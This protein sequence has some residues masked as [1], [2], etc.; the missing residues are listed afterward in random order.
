MDSERIDRWCERGIFG[1]VLLIL[2]FGP[3]AI[4]AVRWFEFIYIEAAT[5]VI[6]ILWLIRS[7]VKPTFELFWPPI[8]W[9]VLAFLLYALGRY[10]TADIEYVARLEFLRICVYAVLFLAVLNNVQRQESIQIII[11]ALV[12]LATCLSLYALVQFATKSAYVWHFQKPANYTYRG[13]G[14]FI[15]PN[16]LAGFLEIAL[17]VALAMVVLGRIG[18]VAKILLGY[19]CAVMLVG[20]GV[21]LSR[22]GWIAT[23]L[24]L[25]CFFI[26]L[27]VH[28]RSRWIIIL[29]MLLV[30]GASAAYIGGS[31]EFQNRFKKTFITGKVGDAR[32]DYWKPAVQ[33][34]KEHPWIGIG[35][36]HYEIRFPQFRPREVQMHPQYAHNDYLNTLADWGIIGAVIVLSFILLLYLG[37]LKAAKFVRRKTNLGDGKSDRLALIFGCSFGVLGL[38]FHSVTDFNMQIP[39][40]AI[41]LLIVVALAMTHLRHSDSFW[42]QNRIAAKSLATIFLL[43]VVSVMSFYGVRKAQENLWLQRA[44]ATPLLDEKLAALRRAATIEKNN[45]KTLNTLG[46]LLRQAS[47]RADDGDPR[48]AEEALTWFQKG[49]KTDPFSP[50]NYLGCGMSLDWLGRTKESGPY[51]EKALAIDPNSYYVVA[52]Q[53]WHAVQLGDYPAAEKWFEKSLGL[54]WTDFAV[55]YINIVRTKLAEAKAGR[56]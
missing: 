49:I 28:S 25:L 44:Q 1:L 51:F 54:S 14:T 22:G 7:W 23:T 8:C 9:P 11:W 26:A 13:S 12:I 40:N 43:A 32:F 34:W 30:F 27:V 20:I 31:L 24:T 4:G 18:H 2:L 33:M 45:P 42:L 52:Y 46:E 56:S 48:K 53:G 55:D 50:Y 47:F 3:L 39:G 19:A 16:H 35:P 36:A 37:A 6:A 41:A 17:P 38:L 15:N 10:L 29:S 21:S 5:V